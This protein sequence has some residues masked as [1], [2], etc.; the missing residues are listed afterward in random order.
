M[1]EYTITSACVGCT[2]GVQR[3]VQMA[4]FQGALL[5]PVLCGLLLWVLACRVQGT[6]GHNYGREKHLLGS[7]LRSERRS[8]SCLKNAS[9]VVWY[10]ERTHETHTR[11]SNTHSHTLHAHTLIHTHK[12]THTCTHAHILVHTHAHALDTHTHTHT[13]THTRTH[14]H[15]HTHTHVHAHTHTCTRVHTHALTHTCTQT[16][17]CTHTHVHTHTH[18]HTHTCTHTEVRIILCSCLYLMHSIMVSYL[19]PWYCSG[20]SAGAMSVTALKKTG[21][22][23]PSVTAHLCDHGGCLSNF[24]YAIR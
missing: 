8:E 17:T 23:C 9:C 12:A 10:I 1:C 20:T 18:T 15:I 4:V 19:V 5:L 16:H 3:A 7:S 21:C 22:G 14:M 2:L 6:E 11:H 13:C 24:S